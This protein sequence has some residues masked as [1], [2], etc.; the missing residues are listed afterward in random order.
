[1]KAIKLV[2]SLCVLSCGVFCGTSRGVVIKVSVS[3]MPGSAGELFGLDLLISD[4]PN[5]P[6]RAFMATIGSISGPSVLTFDVAAS[7]A[8]AGEAA[9][10][11][12]ENTLG[13]TAKDNLD[14]SYTFGDDPASGTTV[15]LVIDDI[16]ARYAFTWDGTEGDYTF[17]LDLDI[18]ESYILLGDFNTHEAL[19]LPEGIWYDY[20]I[21][22]A[23]STSF[24]VHIPEPATL[25]L[26]GLGCLTLLKRRKP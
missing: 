1:M 11:L 9:Y 18:E 4:E 5:P 7:E 23:D 17:T 24:T 12:Y 6:A 20:P 25:A 8:V 26:L 2:I 16:V 13:A 3:Q 19:Q 14:G 10:W 15:P 22:S 21:I